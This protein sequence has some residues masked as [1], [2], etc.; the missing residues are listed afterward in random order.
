MF[1]YDTAL[2]RKRARGFIDTFQRLGV[3]AEVAYASKAFSC[4]AVYQLAAQ[5]NLSLDVVSGG[6]LYTALQAG[7]PSE[8]IH[9]HGNNKSYE[10]LELAFDSKIGCIVVDNFMKLNY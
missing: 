8:R 9:F 7:F 6:E 4:V 3:K 2:I 1:V 10:E 5:E